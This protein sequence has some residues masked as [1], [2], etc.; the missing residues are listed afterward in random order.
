MELRRVRRPLAS[1]AVA[2]G[3]AIILGSASEAIAGAKEETAAEWLPFP[4]WFNDWRNDLADKGFAFGATYIGDNIGNVSGGI[5][6][7]V[8][9]FGRLDLAVDADLDKLIGWT[10]AKLHSDVFGLYG[11]GL[12]HNYIANLATISEIE[13]LPELRLYEAY[14]EQTLW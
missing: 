7:G 3:I 11:R 14:I 2:A 12:T 8:I 1:V 4:K 6:Q 5:K 13:A 10:G 9:H